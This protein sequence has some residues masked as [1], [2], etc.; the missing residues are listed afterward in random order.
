MSTRHR[1]NREGSIFLRKDGR[2]A[3]ALTIGGGRRKTFYG[4]T[5]REV[6]DKLTVALKAREDGLPATNDRLTVAAFLQRWLDESAR[7]TVR[8]RTFESYAATVE[9]HLIPA[10]GHYALTKLK[11]DTVQAYLN[12]K[13]AAGLSARSVQYHHAILRRALGQ[14]ERWGLVVRNVAKL[15]TPPRIVREEVTPLKPK[16]ARAFINAIRGIRLEALYL[17]TLTLG[18]R[19]SE[20]LGLTWDRVDLDAGAVTVDRSLQRYAGAFHLDEVKTRKSR[21]TLPLTPQ[22]T[23]ALRS[24]WARQA[25]ERLRIGPEWR[26]EWNLVFT[27]EWGDPIRRST[28]THG[29]QDILAKAGLPRQRFHDLRHCAATL[30]LS[31]GVPLKVIQE[32]L[33]HATLQTTA[34]IYA[35]VLPELQRDATD[36]VGAVLW[37]AVE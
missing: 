8:P 25:E 10:L 26:D 33:G 2:W 13:H 21:R 23:A 17:V 30:M 4:R 3:A 22:V 35:H 20:V 14:S 18:L 31:Q 7:P 6:A 11:P 15:V 12:G 5:R 29:V 1:G 24:H 34:N 27:T 37:G 16:E 32:V 9:Q 28:V 36:R 19:S